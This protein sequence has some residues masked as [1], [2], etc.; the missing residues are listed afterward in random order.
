VGAGAKVTMPL[1]DQFWGDRYGQ[2]E[3]PFGH[4]WSIATHLRDVTP[5]EMKEAMSKMAS[6]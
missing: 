4:K 6:K 3:D 1:A 2:I 5:E